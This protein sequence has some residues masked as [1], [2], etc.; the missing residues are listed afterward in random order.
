M[1]AVGVFWKQ[2]ETMMEAEELENLFAEGEANV[3]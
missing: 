3:E 1:A 2:I